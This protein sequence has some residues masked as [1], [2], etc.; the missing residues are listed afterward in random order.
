MILDDAEKDHV[1]KLHHR[2]A[3]TAQKNEASPTN[4]YKV[5]LGHHVVCGS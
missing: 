4:S 3:D 2:L 1:R 5:S